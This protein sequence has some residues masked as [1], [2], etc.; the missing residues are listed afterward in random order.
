MQLGCLADFGPLDVAES[1]L[2]LQARRAVRLAFKGLRPLPGNQRKA[3]M[4]V[5]VAALSKASAAKMR[6]NTPVLLQRTKQ[7]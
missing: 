7:M 3:I 4:T 1:N 2:F 6:S 5:S